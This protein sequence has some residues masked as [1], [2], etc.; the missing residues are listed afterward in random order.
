MP[1][2]KSEAHLKALR[3]LCDQAEKLSQVGAALCERLTNRMEAT[4]AS[5][6]LA[7]KLPA[8]ERRRKIRKRL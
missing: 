2:D 6:D 7:H 3:A 1:P 4:K 5:V 8:T